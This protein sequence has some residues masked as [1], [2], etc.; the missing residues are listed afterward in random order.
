ME[1][2]IRKH[3]P[4]TRPDGTEL[5]DVE[6]EPDRD[7]SAADY[8]REQPI[9]QEPK[10]SEPKEPEI[11]T[12]GDINDF[13]K[14]ASVPYTDGSI[15]PEAQTGT[16]QEPHIVP[17]TS[18]TESSITPA[19]L[20]TSILQPRKPFASGKKQSKEDTEAL[21]VIQEA[22][23]AQ[24]AGLQ[25]DHADHEDEIES[26]AEVENPFVLEAQFLEAREAHSKK[27]KSRQITQDEELAFMKLA[28]RYSVQ[29]KIFA[30]ELQKQEALDRKNAGATQKDSLFSTQ[31]DKPKVSGK[32]K[33]PAK[34]AEEEVKDSRSKKK[35]KKK[36]PKAPMKRK[37]G[38]VNLDRSDIVK[39]A[40]TAANLPEEPTFEASNVRKDAL[41]SL[42]ED[43]PKGSSA[44]KDAIRLNNAIK[45]FTG[46]QTVKPAS[47]GQW[48][49]KGMQTTLKNWQT[50]NAG[51]M[52]RRETGDEK[53]KGG[54]IAD[55]M[56]LGKTVT[57][58]A[59][60]VNG[61]P[62][63]EKFEDADI[64]L[65]TYG[66]VEKSW[67]TIVYPPGLPEEDRDDYFTAHYQ[68]ILGPLHQFLWLRIV[69]DEG[70][71]IRNP[72][73]KTT[74]ACFRLIGTHR[75]ILTGTP[76]VN[77]AH[78]LFA[79]FTFVG[80]PTIRTMGFDSFKTTF[81][82]EKDRMSWDALTDD[83]LKTMARF[84][85]AESLFGRRLITLP[86]LHDFVIE[87]NFTRLEREIY[88]VVENR[89]H[90]RIQVIDENGG[91]SS[92]R[93]HILALITLLRQMTAHPLMLQSQISDILEPE[94]FDKIER[95]VEKEI[96][97]AGDG[98][99]RF[100][101]FK[102]VIKH[103]RNKASTHP[104]GPLNI[105]TLDEG[106]DYM[107][108]LSPDENDTGGPHGKNVNYAAY[109]TGLKSSKN[110]HVL[111]QRM[112]CSK[113]KRPAVLP[114]VAPCGHYYCTSH[115]DD[116]F[117]TTAEKGRDRVKC[118][119]KLENGEKC[120][121]TLNYSDSVNPT[122]VPKWSSSNNTIL[123][124]TKTLAFKAQV[125]AWLDAHTG[126]PSAKIIVFTQW[127]TF[128][129]I[130]GC[131]CESEGWKYKTLH[132]KLSQ[133]QKNENIKDFKCNPDTRILL[134]TM[135][136][137]GVGIN[138]T[139]ARYILLTD[140]YWNDAGEQQAFGRVF[141]IGQ[142]RETEVATLIIR[143]SIDK[144]LQGIK[145]RKTKEITKVDTNYKEE[146]R[147]LIEMLV[148]SDS[149]DEDEDA[150]AE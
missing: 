51:F 128:L 114:K 134:A 107:E 103:S 1:S 48:A 104:K 133:K 101:S 87:L 52:R 135:K 94:D 121:R 146:K 70:H 105:N 112:N 21:R 3:A 115:L 57:C 53:P 126:D 78:D 102:S 50:I 113:C 122:D 149:D 73:T 25:G 64:V 140:P 33:R 75:W 27:S 11:Q 124:S 42:K 110:P 83:L 90:Q 97:L 31:R 127:L 117:H 40:E 68:P 37:N 20:G 36:T 35:K 138:L 26:E 77:G 2:S 30:E 5:I 125:L 54:I 15:E 144:K 143:K 95:A 45:S 22:F 89:C 13:L 44:V 116:L 71:I 60:I 6:D 132:G 58:L 136:T 23:F 76:M 9:K 10:Q 100:E 79:Q 49:V 74:Q 19:G 32:R 12:A 28:S 106:E 4:F 14:D 66:D 8:E 141:R 123:P 47:N 98:T 82:N 109:M 18:T 29:K 139:C 38:E 7:I 120:G 130:L 43:A 80:H 65:T 17:E 147:K 72:E 39:D 46:Q 56:G 55:Q 62:R 63:K 88:D 148:S 99:G 85:H 69:L 111:E 131:I 92:T 137:G 96:A 150:S 16:E 81:C 118:I 41:D 93:M 91:S 34:S 67:P 145:E 129:R 61:R 24:M 119:K 108:E 86:A 142:T 59:N 84:T